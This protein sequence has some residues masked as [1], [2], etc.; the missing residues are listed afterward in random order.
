VAA[1]VPGRGVQPTEPKAR[2]A[3]VRPQRVEAEV[4]SGGP[5]CPQ[6]G[7]ANPPGRRFCRRCGAELPA[8]A[9]T[10]P[11]TREPAEGRA[12]WWRRLLRR[13]RR[14]GEAPSRSA[15]A[16]YRRSLDLRYRV[17]RVVAVA[18][19]LG[20]IAG[21]F[22]LVGVNPV[23]GARSLWDRFFPRDE[24]VGELQAATD[25]PGAIVGEFAPG[26]AVDGDADTAWATTWLLAPDAPA[27]EACADDESTPGSTA[28]P[29]AGGDA[30][31]PAPTAPTGGGEAALVIALPEATEL[32]KISVQPGLAS[33][34][35]DRA[36][37]WQPTRLELRFDDGTCT[38]IELADEAGFQ[39][40]RIDAPETSTV[41]V[42]VL[43]AARPRAPEGAGDLV[44]IGEIRLF[45]PK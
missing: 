23:S 22:G 6:C 14:D 13:R 19:G 36:L 18:A 29:A 24:R 26:N 5:D 1:P 39:D 42:S 11:D 16:A 15:R 37:H 28:E 2:P 32:S 34:D 40:H 25:P 33:G 7:T 30:A 27:A 4:A 10:R 44:A 35:P 41:R 9:E 12:P 21:G 20:V 45:A 3:P 8:V 31:A 43:D 38:E 17:L